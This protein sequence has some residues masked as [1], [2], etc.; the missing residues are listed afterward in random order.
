MT[1]FREGS[2]STNQLV[3]KDWLSESDQRRI[4]RAYDFLLRLRTDLHYATVR[5]TDVLHTNLQEQTARRLNYSPQKAQL[6]TEARMRGYDD[7][8]RNICR[9]T[10]RITEHLVR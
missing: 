6:R 1:Y 10:A 4:G 2:L 3:G 5:A 9:V 7:H 8:T